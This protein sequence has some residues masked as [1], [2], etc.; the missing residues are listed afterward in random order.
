MDE[1]KADF[2]TA[3]REKAL[4][5]YRHTASPL[6]SQIGENG[7]VKVWPALPRLQDRL[8]FIAAGYTQKEVAAR[9]GISAKTVW[10]HFNGVLTPRNELLKHY[11]KEFDCPLAWLKGETIPKEAAPPLTTR[12]TD[13]VDNTARKQA[14]VMLTI[15]GVFTGD[16]LAA[17]IPKGVKL[18]VQLTA[19]SVTDEALG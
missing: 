8:R 4:T 18:K 6:K 12:A 14:A 17:L 16:E 15:N 10:H 13:T 2:V 5:G 19:E 11:A 3:N 1:V 7:P 9:M